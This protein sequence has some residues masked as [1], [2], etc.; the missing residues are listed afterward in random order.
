MKNSYSLFALFI[1]TLLVL[2]CNKENSNHGNCSDNQYDGDIFKVVEEM[3][4]FPGCENLG[5]S[6][7]EL[8]K[9][10]DEEILKFINDNLVYPRV[11]ID[12]Q[13]EGRSILTFIIHPLGCLTNIK[14]KRDSGG[15]TG[16]EAARVIKEMPDWIPGKQ[17]GEE[18]AVQITLP[19][20]FKL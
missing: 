11:A 8:K 1:I 12:N 10:S 5:L 14:I 4:R 6:D 19:V 18:V 2:S 13:I 3:P 16:D 9:C 7:D 15:G 17:R 20:N